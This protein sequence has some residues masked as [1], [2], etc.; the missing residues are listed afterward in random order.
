MFWGRV[1]ADSNQRLN[2]IRDVKLWSASSDLGDPDHQPP[3]VGNRNLVL[4]FRSE[5]FRRYPEAIL[6]A[7]EAE[8]DGQGNPLFEREHLPDETAPR[9]WPAFQGAIGEDVTFFGFELTPEAARN[10]WFV[11][12]EPPTGYRFL[13]DHLDNAQVLPPANQTANNGGDFAAQ[14]LYDPTRVLIKGGEFIPEQSN[15]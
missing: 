15:A 8:K 1:D 9:T 12:E 11:L 13:N 5:L 4:A 14:R 10:Y 6:S 2:D 7:V 3:E